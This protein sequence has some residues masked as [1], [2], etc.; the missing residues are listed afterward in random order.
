[1]VI[2]GAALLEYGMKDS[3]KGIDIVCRTERDRDELLRAARELGF[4]LA[5]PEERHARLGLNRIAMRGGHVLD[6]FAGSISSG[7]GLSDG[8]WRRSTLRKVFG[9][10]DVRYASPEDIFIMKLIA[11]REGDIEDC[12]FLVSAGLDF[13]TVYEEIESQYSR[14]SEEKE[15]DQKIWITYI[16]ESIG[17]LE[18]DYGIN[19][20]IGDAISSLADGYR[21]KLYQ[22]LAAQN[23]D[24]PLRG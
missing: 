20:P 15:D 10:A 4:E 19:V 22:R 13:D 16:E 6:V 18:E 14:S 9:K 1:M 17:R 21:E 2:G 8:M 5:S 23:G 7:F 11:G 24:D 3:T 12:A